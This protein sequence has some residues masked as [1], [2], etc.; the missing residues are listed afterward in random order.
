MNQHLPEVHQDGEYQTRLLRRELR[1]HAETLIVL[2][3]KQGQRGDFPADTPRRLARL[4]EVTAASIR[5]GLASAPEKQLKSISGLL[6]RFTEHLRYVERSGIASTP[7]SM[8]QA[9][10]A[11][12]KLQTGP[13]SYFIMRPQWAY[14]YCIVG[15]FVSAYRHEIDACDWLDA[16]AWRSSA[17]LQ[18]KPQIYCMSFPRIERLNCLMHAMWGHEVGHIIANKWIA[19]K[20]DALWRDEVE[21]VEKAI[22]EKVMRNPPPDVSLFK[23]T[24]IDSLVSEQAS[25]VLKVLQHGLTELICDAVGVELM[26]PAAVCAAFEFSSRFEPDV[27]PVGCEYYPPWRYRIRRMLERCKE[28]LEKPTGEQRADAQDVFGPFFLWFARIVDYTKQRLDVDELGSQTVS[29]LAYDIIEIRW[30]AV[31]REALL[32]LVGGGY[33]LRDHSGAIRALAERLS[34]DIPPNEHGQWPDGQAASLPDILNAGWVFKISREETDGGGLSV[35]E[36]AKLNRLLLKGIE[37]SYVH[38][39]FGPAIRDGGSP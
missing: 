21:A 18:G 38:S 28:D 1:R 11:F 20:F 31:A 7:W 16:E 9:T 19:N 30:N 10:E 5:D 12:L 26:G 27:N 32:P 17:D 3:R 29:K 2:A 37:G 36:E 14:N 35:A 23:E 33:R 6:H 13:E 4:I 15:E 22:R 34:A 8:I 25:E 39:T 24:S